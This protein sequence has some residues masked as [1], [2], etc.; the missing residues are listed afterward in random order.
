[1]IDTEA[2]ASHHL[3]VLALVEQ[4]LHSVHAQGTIGIPRLIQSQPHTGS[5]SP[6]ALDED[7]DTPPS[8]VVTTDE[9]VN[10][11]VGLR[12]DK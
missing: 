5:T 12:R 1:M 6:P 3:L 4:E 8:L 10:L 9:L 2:S 7:A 11:L